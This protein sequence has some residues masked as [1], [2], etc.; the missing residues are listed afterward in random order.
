MRVSTLVPA[1]TVLL[2]V[3]GCAC[4]PDFA[5]PT[6]DGQ[7]ETES[8][9]Q[10]APENGPGT[11]GPPEPAE[12]GPAEP[13]SPGPTADD[14]PPE[15]TGPTTGPEDGG[16]AATADEPVRLALGATHTFEDGFTVTMGAVERRTEPAEAAADG[17][18]TA[19]DDASPDE[20]GEPADDPGYEEGEAD[21]DTPE[22]ES[23]PEE[24][25]SWPEED[26]LE[27]PEDAE[28]LEDLEEEDSWAEEDED[29]PETEDDLPVEEPVEE[30]AEESLEDGDDYYAW[31]VDIVNDG[32]EDVY[33]GA[34]LS[35]CSVGDPLTAS[36]APFL[37]E[38]LAPP[39]HLTPE[40][41]AAWDE[42]CWSDEDD[43]TLQ[44]TLE[45]LNE[46]GARLYPVL[47]FE[48]RVD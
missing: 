43:S 35:A 15:E 46:E 11:H 47:V 4:G 14:E 27:D 29:V 37:G 23:W 28:D 18:D 7:Q 31:S 21:P 3:S 45:F 26:D 44:W 41:N 34:V 12:E 13:G 38:A 36:G 19:P 6:G 16:G 22:D 42:D 2:A 30:P 17:S 24:D 10:R 9:G 1:A 8:P 20:D 32:D 39:A 25:E 5:T 40:Q 33:T 48:G